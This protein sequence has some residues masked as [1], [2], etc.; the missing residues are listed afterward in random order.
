[1]M[2]KIKDVYVH[3]CW[4][5]DPDGGF[6]EGYELLE[7]VGGDE[8]KQ[9]VFIPESYVEGDPY[10]MSDQELEQEIKNWLNPQWCHQ[11]LLDVLDSCVIPL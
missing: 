7:K 8:W 4:W 10:K 1:M 9:L 3:H 2:R 5:D 6:S 11:R